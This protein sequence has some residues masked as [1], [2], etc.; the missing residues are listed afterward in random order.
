[1]RPPRR[2]RKTTTRAAAAA[3]GHE[4]G[5]VLGCAVD[6]VVLAHPP[7][8]DGLLVIG[9]VLGQRHEHGAVHQ[10]LVRGEAQSLEPVLGSSDRLSDGRADDVPPDRAAC[11]PLRG[12]AHVLGRPP[13][14]AG[15][16]DV[17]RDLH[18]DLLPAV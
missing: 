11:R 4:G 9:Q 13:P 7:S 12:Q 5:S 14:L 1:M 3:R 8:D 18:A 10:L 2:T 15:E 16:G 17:D 6:A